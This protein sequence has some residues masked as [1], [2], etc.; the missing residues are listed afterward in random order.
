MSEAPLPNSPEAREADG[1]LKPAPTLTSASSE[2]TKETPPSTDTTKETPEPEAKV[3]GEKPAV[4]EKYEFTAPEGQELDEKFT[5]EV[6]AIF[7]EA[8]LTQELAAKLNKLYNDKIAGLAA[9][10]Q[11]AYEQMRTGWRNETTSDPTLG[12]GTDLKPEVKAVLGRA[13]DSM[14]AAAAPFRE[15]MDLIGAGD[16]PA[17][18]RGLF[19]L[20]KRVGEGTAVKGNGPAPVKDPAKPTSVAH[21]LYPNLS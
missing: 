4:P 19:A 3:E 15:A 18:I 14:G 13:I 2:T 7:K 9:A 16:H 6:S 10:P 20:A 12:N 11:Q 5:G 17:V 8:G 1:T 21:A